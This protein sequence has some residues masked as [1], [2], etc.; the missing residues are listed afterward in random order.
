MILEKPGERDIFIPGGATSGAMNNDRVIVRV[1]NRQ[2]REGRIIKILERAHTRIVGR[3]DVTSEIRWSGKAVSYIK[4]KN[5]DITFN[6]YIPPKDRGKAKNGDTVVAE[7]INYPSEKGPPGGRIV[8]IIE[9]PEDP[10]SDVEAIID[11]FNIP[12]RFPRDVSEETIVELKVGEERQKDLTTLHTV[13]NDGECAKDFDDAVSIKLTGHGYRLW[14]HITD[15]GF[16]V[17]W[18]SAID[19]EARKRGTSINLIFRIP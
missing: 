6:L 3:L 9:K 11:E 2:R 16:Y 17:P 1:E 13:T 4:P 7:I 5:K 15:V 10:P 12:R 8:K 18:D 14:V 19:F